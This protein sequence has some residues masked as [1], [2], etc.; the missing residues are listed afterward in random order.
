M[1]SY[2]GI[3]IECV[4]GVVPDPGVDHFD[5]FE[6]R[7]R[8]SQLLGHS[9]VLPDGMIEIEIIE[10]HRWISVIWWTTCQVVLP[11]CP[12]MHTAWVDG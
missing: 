3:L 8:G 5:G 7:A 12:H 6:R 4:E 11:I 9:L 10:F 1:R 2:D